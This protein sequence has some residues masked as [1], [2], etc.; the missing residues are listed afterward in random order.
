MRPASLC[1]LGAC[2]AGTLP[3]AIAQPAAEGPRVHGDGMPAPIT[4]APRPDAR[5]IEAPVQRLPQ[6]LEAGP[7]RPDAPANLERQS[8]AG[9]TLAPPAHSAPIRELAQLRR[10]A[11]PRSGFGSSRAAADAAWTLGLLHLHGGL[12]PASPALAQTWF[13]R[14]AP[15][16]RQPLVQAGLAWCLID[17][18]QGPPDPAGAQQAIERLRAR[19]AG[20]ALYLEWL[21]RTRLQPMG[22]MGEARAQAAPAGDTLP[23]ISLLRRAAAAGDAQ[24]RLELGIDAAQRGQIA[25]ARRYFQ[26]A[27]ARSPAAAANLR[28]L[29]PATAILPS[30]PDEANAA[31]LFARARQFHRGEGVPAN[32][33]EAIR[34]YRLAASQGSVQAQRMLALI[35]ARPNPDGSLNVAWMA[36]L[37][38]LD[39]RTAWAILAPL[40]RTPWMQRDATPLYDLLPPLWQRR[41]NA[42]RARG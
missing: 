3:L 37:S 39:T 12:L 27:A 21:L 20:R 2:L 34:L 25:E 16:G 24:A 28:A 23:W 8:Q 17:G 36:Q 11:E 29:A 31:S 40:Q 15:Q 18:C 38:Q 41:M 26:A 13:Q 4:L 7:L 32:Y 42:A 1:L 9:P 30:V 35:A 22:S 5:R 6:A 19:D 10:T 14:A 33:A